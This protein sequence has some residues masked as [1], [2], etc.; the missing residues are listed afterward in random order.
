MLAA[1][2]F[3]CVAL[4]T[5]DSASAEDSSEKDGNVVHYTVAASDTLG[6][7]ALQFGVDFDD[8][9]A[10]NELS[11]LDVPAGT[12]IIVKSDKD[13]KKKPSKPLPVIHVIRPGDTFED[14]ANDYH[15]TTAKVKRWN[16]RLNPRRLQIGQRVRL[17]IPGRGGKS[18]SYGRASNGRL[19]NGVALRDSPGLNVRT[20][21][22]AYAT[23]RTTRLLQAALAD[24]KARWPDAPAAIAG[25]LSHKRGGHMNPHASHQSGRDAD[26]SYYFR[27]NV[28]LP[29]L[30]PMTYE[31]IDAVKTWH[32]FKTLIDTG[33]VEY[34]FAVRPVQ[35]RLYEYA[36]SIG[37]T[38]EELKPLIQYPRPNHVREGIIRHVD[39]HDTHFHIRFTCGPQDRQCR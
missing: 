9:R 36:R 6:S 10:W 8:V 25:D 15:V 27:G 38:A 18:V 20:V 39:G 21:S 17:Y 37:Y 19:Y 32:L 31:T 24:V 13:A 14:I 33:Q 3:G 28:Q 34:I 26:I 23:R 22:R 5:V 2:V 11:G 35:R 29:N 16:R 7:I 30:F 1:L 4:G 12:E